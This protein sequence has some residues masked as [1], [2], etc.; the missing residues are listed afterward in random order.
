MM[1]VGE[2]MGEFWRLTEMRCGVKQIKGLVCARDGRHDFVQ[3][4]RPTRSAGLSASGIRAPL[5]G[6]PGA[7]SAHLYSL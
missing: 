2:L 1:V 6:A 5:I 4:C 3:P 7:D